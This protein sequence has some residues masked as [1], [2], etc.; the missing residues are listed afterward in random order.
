V[1]EL[2][3]HALFVDLDFEIAE[4]HLVEPVLERLDGGELQGRAE[5]LGRQIDG[6]TGVLASTSGRTASCSMR[7]SAAK[8]PVVL[9]GGRELGKRRPRARLSRP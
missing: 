7:K 1:L 2:D 8:L 9:G 3:E 5:P 6:G 4:V